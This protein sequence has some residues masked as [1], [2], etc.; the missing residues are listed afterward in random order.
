MSAL[1][2]ER[3]AAHWTLVLD[4]P[5]KVNAL[6]EDLVEALHA[7]LLDAEAARVDLV[8]LRGAGRN[9]S[10]GFDFGGFEMAPEGWEP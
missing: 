4:R 5:D 6:S 9:F 7:A 2:I 8:V 10:A 1:R 3:G